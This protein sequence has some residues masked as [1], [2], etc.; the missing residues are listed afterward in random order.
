MQ[1][2]QSTADFPMLVTLG[3]KN[4]FFGLNRFN[5]PLRFV[6]LDEEKFSLSGGKQR[7]LYKGKQRSHRFTILG[8]TSFEYDC[9]LEKPP[10]SNTVSLLIEGAEN[11]DFF[12][13][14]EFVKDPFLKGSYAVYK[15]ETLLGEGTGK[16][17][18]IHRPE[19]IDARG[20]RCW[21]SLAVTGNTLRITIPEKWLGEAVYP[22][23]VDPTVGTTTVGKQN[24]WPDDRFG[25]LVEFGMD[26]AVNRFLAP[27]T[28][29]GTCMAYAY[30]SESFAD[31][32][33]YG[34]I[35][36]DN[37]NKPSK[38]NSMEEEWIDMSY[39][40][41]SEGWE[42][43]SFEVINPIQSGSSIWFGILA[44]YLWYPLFDFG[45]PCYFTQSYAFDSPPETFPA[46]NYYLDM[47]LSMYFTYINA[48]N[49][50]RKITHGVALSDNRK[51]TANYKRNI[52][53]TVKI[54]SILSR[55]EALC[56]KCTMAVYNTM[57]VSRLQ[58]LIRM[59]SVYI[60]PT[61]ANSES[62]SLSRKCTENAVV[63]S[64][65]KRTLAIFRKIQDSLNGIDTQNFSVLFV[66]SVPD[67]ATASDK[68]RH[69]AS[70]IRCL[71][72]VS[73]TTAETSHESIYHRKHSDTAHA[74]GTVLRNLFLFIRIATKVFIRDYLLGRF[75]KARKELVLKS[76]ICREITLE[77]KLS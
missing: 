72:A 27:E 73:E 21:G 68:N 19:I 8:D 69:S 54:N 33:G 30:T 44:N 15:K 16:L 77:S 20:R 45:S 74:K 2:S 28:I 36:T 71:L 61:T 51:L 11:Y 39:F 49:H 41:P 66:R 31:V 17:C 29:K 4:P 34:V 59:L 75:L 10:D 35:Y 57:N 37:N 52:N 56:R 46:P 1:F 3:E 13:Q 43:G 38:L 63:H 32:G 47:K 50:V 58:A 14:P 40:W 60:K 5:K 67:T 24:E 26:F 7:L 18:H 6:P 65:T 76:I 42:S 64:E 53:H 48:Q 62:R 12:R 70:F 25:D 23:I 55:F 22:V 9:I